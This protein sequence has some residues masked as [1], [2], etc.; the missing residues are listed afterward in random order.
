MNQDDARDRRR[1]AD[2]A[3]KRN[4]RN[5][6]KSAGYRLLPVYV[7]VENRV[8]VLRAIRASGGIVGLAAATSKGEHGDRP[9]PKRT[10]S[11]PERAGLSEASQQSVFSF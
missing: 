9:L 4:A 10:K 3:A 1:R 8:A 6:R 11:A 2:A 5:A 7:T